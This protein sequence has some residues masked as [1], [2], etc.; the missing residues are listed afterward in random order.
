MIEHR[1]WKG[2]NYESG[3]GGKRIAIV[4]HSHYGDVDYELLTCTIVQGVI[5]GNEALRFF[6]SI[7]NFF[8][9]SSHAEFWNR[10]VF[11]NYL[12]SC[13]GTASER[14]AVGSTEQIAVAKKRFV[15]LVGQLQPA[16]V[17]VFT[18]SDDKGWQTFP[19]TDQEKAGGET[20]PLQ[21]FTGFRWGTYTVDD[22]VA[23]AFGLRHPQ[24]A[25][26]N[27]MRRAVEHILAI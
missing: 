15:R 11:F 21:G 19:E 7:R 20:L 22:H 14:F 27:L 25:D 5:Q 18:N 6:T 8:G 1:P 26:G 13:V 10:V 24:W 9:Y 2:S 3:I 23:T 4:G 12:P 16:K 17:F